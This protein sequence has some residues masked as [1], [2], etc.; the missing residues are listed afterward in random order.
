MPKFCNFF[1]ELLLMF[2]AYH[3]HICGSMCRLR[4]CGT[5]YKSNFVDVYI[6]I[7]YIN[8]NFFSKLR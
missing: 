1:D 8:Y 7:R 5:I 6:L 4:I 2:P 3:G